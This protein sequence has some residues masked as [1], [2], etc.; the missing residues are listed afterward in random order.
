MKK[1]IL[2]LQIVLC[3]LFT[4]SQGQQVH[5]Q[6]SSGDNLEGAVVV[7]H[8]LSDGKQEARFTNNQGLATIPKFSLPISYKVTYLG[9]ES[10]VDTIHSYTSKKKV[11][12]VALPMNFDQVT[13]TGNYTPGFKS[14]SI[15]NI[16]VISNKEIEQRAVY[17]VRDLMTQ[18]L[19]VQLSNDGVLGS[20]I[21]LQ[22]VGGQHV[23]FLIDGVPVIGRQNGN[24]DVSQLNLA[25]IDHIEMVKG[26]MSVLYGSDALGGVINLI[27][28]SN[29]EERWNGNATGYYESVG[30]YN[31][32]I[33]L[34]K[35]F[36]NSSLFFNA[37]RNFFDGWSPNDSLRSQQWNP[38]EQYFANLK[39][40]KTV[41]GYKMTLQYNFSNETVFNKGD[42]T[43]TPY[44]AYAF[45]QDFQTS[46]N[47]ILFTTDKKLND[48]SS[49][50]FTAAYNHYRY[51]KNAYRKNLVDL[52]SLL[53]EDPSDDDTTIFQSYFTRTVYNHSLSKKVSLLSGLELNQETAQGKKIDNAT[54][55]ITDAALFACVDYNPTKKL[56]I[57]SS[58]RGIY[59]SQY[60]APL[61]PSLN[62]LYKISD[63]YAL[64]FSWSKGFRA[65]SIK[66][67]YLYFV[68]A[69]H[70]VRGNPNLKAEN[71][72]NFNFSF[73]VKY[74]KSK[75][76]IEI[77]PALFYNHIR[78]QISLAQ[79]DKY[80]SLFTYINLDE[81]TAMGGEVQLRYLVN[82]F[83]IKS[84]ISYTGTSATY[85]GNIKQE[86]QAWYFETTSSASYTIEKWETSLAL[87]CKYTGVKPVYLLESDN[88]ISLQQN[89]AY[90]LMDFTASKFFFKKKL[91]ISAGLKNIL[92]V[93]NVNAA[94]N[95]GVHAGNNNGTMMVGT[96][97]SSFVKLNYKF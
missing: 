96:G 19:N 78:N 26:P 70:N 88:T 68:D 44:Q 4:Y 35:G 63:V 14:N 86:D 58:L 90:T 16:D 12:L 33:S 84:G 3:S 22:G 11:S 49:W 65:P 25:N 67:Q 64:R 51:I 41:N 46:R 93:Q 95:N 36:K 38:K 77:E 82:S 87:F 45:D 80:T 55:Q 43:I 79:A 54:H 89:A 29:K 40:N 56:T 62:A 50:Q 32:D 9:F 71:S 31:T 27:T 2:A 15:Y 13:V 5:V 91:N 92:D 60:K 52:S 18:Q 30:N 81:F 83:E 47:Q 59:N 97:R 17:N 57:R 94:M 69:S 74:V 53:T 42:I 39:Y 61:V 21:S 37:G 66:E 8:S 28:K 24:V 23:K 20:S 6:I 76:V 85:N 75:S 48:K 72:D 1:R 34:G 10:F 73:N 7:F